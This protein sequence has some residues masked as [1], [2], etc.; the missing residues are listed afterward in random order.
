[1]GRRGEHLEAQLADE[2]ARLICDEGMSDYRAARLKAAERLGLSPRSAQVDNLRIEAA[3]LERQRLFGGSAYTQRLRAMRQTAL[4]A[5]Q[6]LAEFRPRLAGGAV[7]GAIGEG[8]RVQLQVF[9]DQAEIVEM[10][11][12]DRHVAFDQA[13][14]IYRFADGRERQIPLLRFEAGE[15]GIDVAIFDLEAERNRP[16]SNI[17]GKPARQLTPEQVRGLLEV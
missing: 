10:R 5:M 13:E 14:R 17:D 1:M 3:V 8:H 2:A 6:W 4:R 9:A 12:H 11:L 7:S 15:I 16:L